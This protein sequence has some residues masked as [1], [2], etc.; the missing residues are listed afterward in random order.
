MKNYLL[1]TYLAVFLITSVSCNK[2]KSILGVYAVQDSII[3]PPDVQWELRSYDL[4]VSGP[5]LFSKTFYVFN[6]AKK[7]NDFSGEKFKVKCKINDDIITILE[8]EVNDVI[9]HNTTGHFSNDSIFFDFIFEN[10]FGEVFF[11]HCFGAKK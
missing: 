7:N 9:V 2:N 8:Q 6:Y 11:G 4:E 5:G 1:L 10:K 3:G